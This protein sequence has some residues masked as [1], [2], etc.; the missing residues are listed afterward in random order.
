MNW[1]MN[2]SMHRQ[3]LKILHAQAAMHTAGNFIHLKC[4]SL[5]D[6]YVNELKKSTIPSVTFSHL[7]TVCTCV[8]GGSRVKNW[9]S[10]IQW[11]LSLL[12]RPI[13]VP[14]HMKLSTMTGQY[15]SLDM[16]LTTWKRHITW[17]Y[18]K[19]VA[20]MHQEYSPRPQYHP[21]LAFGGPIWLSS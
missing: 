17:H 15:V 11:Y 3:V 12:L 7:L 6:A 9:T 14:S 10:S 2:W 19:R 1:S 20:H 16:S 8:D 4:N 13:L 21:F 18:N 5:Y